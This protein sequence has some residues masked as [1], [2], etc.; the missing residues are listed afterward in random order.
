[1][2]ICMYHTAILAIEQ[3][4]VFL[5]NICVLHGF[6]MLT[7][8][9]D[10]SGRY[11]ICEATVSGAQYCKTQELMIKKESLLNLNITHI[12]NGSTFMLISP[13]AA[14]VFY[15]TYYTIHSFNLNLWYNLGDT[16]TSFQSC[17]DAKGFECD[18]FVFVIL[19]CGFVSSLSKI[20]LSLLFQWL[21]YTME[22]LIFKTHTHKRN[23]K[24]DNYCCL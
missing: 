11:C 10:A 5:C 1:M 16:Q 21:N 24:N 3:W 6:L 15:C 13:V 8:S 19:W 4:H 18:T 20:V 9:H 17:A 12:K 22:R 14:M 23:L 7:S 2:C